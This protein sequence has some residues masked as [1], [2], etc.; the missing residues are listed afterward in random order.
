[1][2]VRKGVGRP[3]ILFTICEIYEGM[4]RGGRWKLDRLRRGRRRFS[5]FD[6][7]ESSMLE[8]GERY[9]M[10]GHIKLFTL[11]LDLELAAKLDASR[12]AEVCHDKAS[13]LSIESILMD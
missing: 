4:A 11:Q 1:M 7:P 12:T 2:G 6:L 8:A 13:R 5:F 9:P 3:P 10:K